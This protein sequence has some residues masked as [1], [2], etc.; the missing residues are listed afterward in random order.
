MVAMPGLPATR[1]EG[2]ECVYTSTSRSM[3]IQPDPDISGIG[4]VIS[5]LVTAWLVVGLIVVYY[6]IY[7]NPHLRPRDQS[8][9]DPDEFRANPFDLCLYRAKDTSSRMIRSILMS[10]A[11]MIGQAEILTNLFG[12]SRFG[13]ATGAGFVRII[14]ALSDVQLF[15][16]LSLVIGGFSTAQNGMLGYHWKMITRLAWFSTL[17]HLAAL[18]TWNRSLHHISVKQVLRL[19]LMSCLA[20]MLVTAIMVT[21]DTG[22]DDDYYAVCY[23]RVPR[24]IFNIANPDALSSA[25]L[26]VSNILIR[27]CKMRRITPKS[28]FTMAKTRVILLVR[29]LLA[30]FCI[31]LQKAS[32]RVNLFVI[33]VFLQPLVGFMMYLEITMHLISSTA[34]EI[35][36]LATASAWGTIR[37]LALR[38]KGPSGED[39]WSFG[40]I[41]P[42]AMFIAP[43]FI[44]LDNLGISAADHGSPPAADAADELSRSPVTPPRQY[45][46]WSEES[47]IS[48]NTL[49]MRRLLYV[50]R[51]SLR[52]TYI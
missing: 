51:L 35:Y 11:R 9:G 36:W 19:I 30:W 1:S 45:F 25:I 6:A 4:M 13:P 52:N 12:N 46:V 18:S 3:E 39:D 28:T 50:E 33:L 41:L 22:F 48:N 29:Q 21:A 14:T 24:T 5:F 43:V 27:L 2:I 20:I 15:T 32:L 26:I 37:L 40:Q 7:Y 42:L 8:G 17:T 31:H 23:M 49:P 10:S 47:I 44:V 38:S 16:G 34:F